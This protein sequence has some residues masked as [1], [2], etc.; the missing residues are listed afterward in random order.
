MKAKR[1]IHILTWCVVSAIGLI[2]VLSWL[3][4][5]EA[6]R[7]ADEVIEGW[8]EGV[9]PAQ[10]TRPYPVVRL[11][12]GRLAFPLRIPVRGIK[13]RLFGVPQK[14]KLLGYRSGHS[15]AFVSGRAYRYPDLTYSPIYYRFWLELVDEAGKRVESAPETHKTIIAFDNGSPYGFIPVGARFENLTILGRAKLLLT[16]VLTRFS[17][18][19]YLLI[20]SALL[21]LVDFVTMRR[22]ESRITGDQRGNS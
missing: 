6:I 22:G 16:V 13:E 14:H 4:K 11:R 8:E 18:F 5:P 17:F 10:V 2:A 12:D 7:H 20:V 15:Q 21:V 1:V 19:K 9:L 3:M